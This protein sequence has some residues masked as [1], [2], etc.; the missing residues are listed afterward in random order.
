MKVLLLNNISNIAI[1][2]F[3]DEK[4]EVDIYNQLTPN[5]LKQ[6]IG[7]YHIV[8]IR[9]KTHL[10]EDILQYAKNLIVIGH[11]CIGT[12]QTNL[13]YA[14]TI[15]IPV[16]NSPFCNTRSVAELVIG[17]MIMLSRKIGDKNTEMH[18]YIWNKSS[19]TCYELR[20]KILG[21]IGYGSIGGQLSVIAESLGMTVI[22]YDILPKQS[23]GNAKRCNTLN[24]LFSRSNFVSL[25]VPLTNDTDNMITTKELYTMKKNS[26]LINTSRGRVVNIEDVSN[27]L[28]D[29][30]LAGVAFDVYPIE[31]IKNTNNFTISLQECDNVIMT[32]HMGG[33]TEEAQVNIALDVSDKIINYIKHGCLLG[34]T[35][36]PQIDLPNHKGK[37][38]ILNIHQNKPGFM[39]QLNDLLQN[40]NISGQI[41]S[42]QDNIGCTIVELDDTIDNNLIDNIN[43]LKY[44]I[45]TR[46]L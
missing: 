31:P 1:N 34:A 8:G 10:S 32:P 25:H 45:S 37:M 3:K 2:I 16:F 40:V 7:Q 27:A 33:S 42:T 44:S 39:N 28:K 30:H 20:S 13:N 38:R 4:Y 5:E 21:I 14:R 24:D 23:F 41:L 29:K 12:D 18:N 26:Y 17:F 43:Q 35:N 9:S 19:K 46:I 6:I 15:G 22:Y 11:F 36:F